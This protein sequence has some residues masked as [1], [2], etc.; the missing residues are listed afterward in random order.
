MV[1]EAGELARLLSRSGYASKMLNELREKVVLL[2]KQVAGTELE[3]L[4][5]DNEQLGLEV[6]AWRQ[7]LVKAEIA[8]GKVQIPIPCSNVVAQCVAEDIHIEKEKEI[9]VE[10]KEGGDVQPINKDKKEAKPKSAKENK[11]KDVKDKTPKDKAVAG[12]GKQEDGKSGEEVCVSQLDLRV[13]L[14]K[15]VEKHPDADALY[16]EQIDIG[17]EKPRTVVSGLV[18]FI[19]IEEMQNRM[20]V[21]M[22]NLKP[23]KMRGVVSEAMVM[24]ASTPDKVEPLR[25]PPTAV[26]GDRVIWAGLSADNYPSPES[27][28]NPKKKIWERIAP[29]LKTNSACEAVWKT[30][31]LS[32]AGKGSLK[33]DTLSDAPVK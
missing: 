15:Q 1:V 8:N 5:R 13:G 19:P 11:S 16:L 24:C 18:K 27:V 6:E 21:V 12:G 23:A 7:R 2:R 32:V 9:K 10:K 26:P 33:A 25:P 22:C 14:I 20:C 28:L 30:Q 31:V 4:R 29:D 17:E 3:H